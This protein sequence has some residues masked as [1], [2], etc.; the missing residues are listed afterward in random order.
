VYVIVPVKQFGCKLKC[1]GLEI[2]NLTMLRVCLHPHALKS[3]WNI[4]KIQNPCKTFKVGMHLIGIDQN[5][6]KIAMNGHYF[7]LF[8]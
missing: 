6:L 8:S 1:K 7:D 5:Y 4:I 3:L 2:Y